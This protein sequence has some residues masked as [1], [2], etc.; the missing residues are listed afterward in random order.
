[1]KDRQQSWYRRF[2]IAAVVLC[3]V[4]LALLAAVIIIAPKAINSGEVRSR[5]EAVIAKEL[6]GTF[7]YDRADLSLLPRPDV[8]LNGVRIDIPGT[9][10]AT[11]SAVR[12]RARLL[13]LFRGQFAVSSIALEKPAL[14]LLFPDATAKRRSGK[15]PGKQPA[16]GSLDKAL[17][18]ASRELPDLTIKLSRGKISMVRQGHSFLA[19]GNLEASLAFVLGQHDAPNAETAGTDYH[20]TGAARATLSE[21]ASFPAP[22]TVSVDRFNAGPGRLMIISA[23]I[24]LQD[25]DASISGD[26]QGHFTGSPR[27]DLQARGTIGPEALSWLQ[28]LADLP[29]GISIRAPL[30]VTAA[31]L[32]STGTG[33]AVS[34]TL[35]VNA[36]MDDYTTLALALRQEPGL[37]S[38]DSLHVKDS[39]SD[40]N[41]KFSRGA[42]GIDLSFAGNL[43]GATIDRILERGPLSSAWLKGDLRAQ[44]PQGTWNAAT[45]HGSLE[46]GR[47]ALPVSREIPVI[48]DRFT[49]LADGSTLD[50]SSVALSLGQDIVQM[51]GTVSLSGNG[52]ELDLDV[53][54]DRIS[55]STLRTM[56]ERKTPEQQDGKRTKPGSRPGVSGSVR[57]RAKAFLFDR[58][59]SEGLDV[60]VI[61]GRERTEAVLEHASL[62]GITFTGSLLTIGSEIEIALTPNARGKSLEESLPCIFHKDMGISGPY[63]LSAKL[64]SRGTWDTLL[65]SLEGNFIFSSS[66]G[67]IQSDHVVKGVIAYLNSTSLLKGSHDKLLKEG[68]PYETVALR[69]TLRDGSLS[70]S[71]CVIKSRDL[72]IAA[73]GKINL[74]EGTLALDVLAAPFT[75]L[76][77]L[78]GNV[79]LVKYLVG[80]ALV[81]VPARVEGTFEHPSVKPL[82]VSGVGMNVTNLMK[83]ALAAPMKIIDPI[84]PKE[85]EGKNAPPKE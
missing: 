4:V 43:T 73:D 12:V 75:R 24:R 64:A 25:L 5:I 16:V 33:S 41:I 46:G 15:P 14:T 31:R 8:V 47:F 28:K 84:I 59:Q 10:S 17:A 7:T 1:V 62:C 72:Q 45:I 76:D 66:K 20:V 34:R 39:D 9:L 54:T 60:N 21:V 69:G 13:P 32:R 67:R 50:L 74:R 11:I 65:R 27:S 26:L 61:F 49:L 58:Y 85:L 44:A 57:L 30:T 48:L 63:E 36:R 40:G 3:G 52:V 82:P 22:L 53:A 18:V 35:T 79:P 38:I 70:L 37:F 2:V 83:N 55:L 78:L 81:V 51:N 29:E 23:R 68:V 71:E 77:R 56:V 80:N 6:N 42:G 19:L